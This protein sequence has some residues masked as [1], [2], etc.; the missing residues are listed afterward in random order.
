MQLVGDALLWTLE[1]GVGTEWTDE[2][3]N[4]WVTFYGFITKEMK[5]GMNL[6]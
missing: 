4:A 2:V 3:K 5:T 1:Q 6:E